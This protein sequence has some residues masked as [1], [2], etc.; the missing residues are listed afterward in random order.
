MTVRHHGTTPA[1]A[2]DAA[3]YLDGF[4]YKRRIRAVVEP[5]LVYASQMGEQ[6][7][8]TVGQGAHVRVKGLGLGCW[9][10]T[11]VQEALMK[12]VYAEVMEATH[13]PGIDVLEFAFFPSGGR[14]RESG[15]DRGEGHPLQLCRACWRAPA[16]GNVCLG[17]ECVP[18]QRVVGRETDYG[19]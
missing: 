13:L 8:G 4:V 7:R 16:S 2:A 12:Q 17:L 1:H 5:F 9:W 3:S 10:V 6:H 11:P 14:A 18:R 19:G 15:V